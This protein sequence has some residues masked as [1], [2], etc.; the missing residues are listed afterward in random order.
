MSN[1]CFFSPVKLQLASC[2]M[3]TLID[4][5]WLVGSLQ[6]TS[7]MPVSTKRTCHM[8]RVAYV[9][10][11]AHHVAVSLRSEMTTST[12][13]SLTMNSTAETAVNGETSYK[14]FLSFLIPILMWVIIAKQSNSI[15]Y[16]QKQTVA[17]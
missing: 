1:D 6:L 5:D 16:F 17:D 13:K 11:S 3:K 7:C 8:V 10:Q 15:S 4:S 12:V 14:V 9:T 2:A